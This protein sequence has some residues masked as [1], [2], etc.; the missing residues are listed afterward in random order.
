MHGDFSRNSF[1]RRNRFS[2]VLMQQGRV[3]MD[4]DWNENTAILLHQL[5]SLAAHIVGPHGGPEGEGFE[6]L[7]SDRTNLAYDFGV[8]RGA[9][10]V[11]GILCENDGAGPCES[12]AEPVTYKNQPYLP[13]EPEAHQLLENRYLVYLD[14]WE[15]HLNSIQ[16][17][18]I[19]EVA[20]GGPDTATRAQVVWQVKVALPPPD[21]VPD[22]CQE[23]LDQVSP[24]R[25]ACLRAQ[26]KFEEP[27]HDPCRLPPQARYRGQ[28]N[29]LYR[30]EIHDPS[31]PGEH[32]PTF[33]WSR[34]NGSVVFAIR[35][36]EGETVSLAS[37]GRDGTRSLKEGDWVEV[38]DDHLSLLG[39]A[40]TLARVQSVDEVEYSVTLGLDGNEPLPPF[41]P[42]AHPLL[43]RWDQAGPAIAVEEEQWLELE[44]GVQVQFAATG[45][46]RTGDYWLVPARTALADVVWPKQ[47]DEPAWVAP[48]G[49]E[50]HYAPLARIEVNDK[51]EVKRLE[52]CRCTFPPLC[53]SRAAAVAPGDPNSPGGRPDAEAGLP[54]APPPAT[55]AEPRPA[56][57]VEA[58][59]GRSKEAALVELGKIS[60]VTSRRAE[61]FFKAGHTT[62]ASV[63]ALSTDE[64]VEVLKALRVEPEVADEIRKSARAK[65]KG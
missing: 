43:R 30:V 26:A 58:A 19:R 55:E 65:T 28:E 34:D 3:L 48:S 13:F 7:D 31:Q 1:D 11:Q 5:R 12:D 36:M 35:G 33:K 44:D 25:A 4:A 62:V 45:S 32:G 21:G 39:R 22:T 50:H 63:A 46:Y 56:P 42:S 9:Y 64:V 17:E 24:L 54:G 52:D 49:I 18:G 10:Y 59:P 8:G 57:G 60:R 53:A 6:T 40:G 38:L 2:R 29:Q 14:V 51:G 16:A 37:L 20:L 15:R 23:W 27:I 41:R 47:G 61:E